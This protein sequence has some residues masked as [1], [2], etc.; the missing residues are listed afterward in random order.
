MPRTTYQLRN[1]SETFMVRAALIS[2]CDTIRYLGI[3]TLSSKSI[4]SQDA[5]CIPMAEHCFNHWPLPQPYCHVRLP[6][7]DILA[8][9][10]DILV[11][12]LGKWNANNV[13]NMRKGDERQAR[14]I[15]KRFA[16]HLALFQSR[17]RRAPKRLMYL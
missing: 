9:K 3:V 8:I 14:A 4:Q 13:M 15:A 10:G 16:P 6:L 5:N 12:R 2:A 11:M 7:N 17:Q 1:A